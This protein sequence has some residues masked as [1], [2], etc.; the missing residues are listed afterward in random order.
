MSRITPV[1]A[2]CSSPCRCGRAASGTWPGAGMWICYWAAFLA[3]AGFWHCCGCGAVATVSRMGLWPKGRQHT[4]GPGLQK[5]LCSVVVPEM[6]R[7]HR[8]GCPQSLHPMGSLLLRLVCIFAVK[9]LMAFFAAVHSSLTTYDREVWT[10]CCIT[11]Q[12]RH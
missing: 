2:V 5:Q 9:A 1:W 12:E 4:D 11:L 3:G 10:L 8:L 7:S 6:L